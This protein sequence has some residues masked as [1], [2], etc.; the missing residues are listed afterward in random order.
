M[1]DGAP[2]TVFGFCTTDVKLDALSRTP[3]AASETEHL[4]PRNGLGKFPHSKTAQIARISQG[5]NLTDCKSF[6]VSFEDRLNGYQ[7][8]ALKTAA[9]KIGVP[10]HQLC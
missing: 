3:L 2:E 1:V 8:V 9:Q 4:G 10:E 6:S 5:G 7:R